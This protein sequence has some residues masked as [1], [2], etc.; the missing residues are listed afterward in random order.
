LA[1]VNLIKRKT[2]FLEKMAERKGDADLS[3]T[4]PLAGGL[5]K[6]SRVGATVYCMAMPSRP[7]L[8]KVIGPG[9]L[10]TIQDALYRLYKGAGARFYPR[11]TTAS[12][13]HLQLPNLAH[14]VRYNLVA[15]PLSQLVHVLRL[16]DPCFDGE[17]SLVEFCE[18][19]GLDVAATFP[20][21]RHESG[22]KVEFLRPYWFDRLVPVQFLPLWME[23][24]P[25]WWHRVNPMGQNLRGLH[26]ALLTAAAI[27]SY[28]AYVFKQIELLGRNM[29]WVNFRA[30]QTLVRPC[31]AEEQ[32]LVYEEE[33]RRL[34]E[35][36]EDSKKKRELLLERMT[37][38]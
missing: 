10:G 23:R 13:P 35:L 7:P 33:I 3:F 16:H 22:G 32:Q 29:D 17:E 1:Q 12:A 19:Y 11:R 28:P 38:K 15:I 21:Q 5:V 30:Q 31:L 8:S 4:A 24:L 2:N 6:T 34:R 25:Q 14:Q 9:P 37:K 26:M 27:R 36:L 20:S 18:Q